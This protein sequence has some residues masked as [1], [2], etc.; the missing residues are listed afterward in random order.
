VLLALIIVWLAVVLATAAWTGLRGWRLWVAAR[1]AQ[2]DV[3][4]HILHAELERLPGRLAELERG[5]ARLS[6]ALHRLQVSVA[7]FRVLWQALTTVSGR[8]TSARAFFTSK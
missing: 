5:Q 2:S 4:R 3:E 7:E 6:E 8:L 1:A